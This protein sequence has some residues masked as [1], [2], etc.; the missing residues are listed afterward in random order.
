VITV[1][2]H[3]KIGTSS[4]NH[5]W[6]GHYINIPRHVQSLNQFGYDT[7]LS[8]CKYYDLHLHYTNNIIIIKYIRIISVGIGME[9][10]D[11]KNE[12][13]FPSITQYFFLS[14]TQ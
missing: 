7:N 3:S 11:D 14:P 5:N 4:H 12:W 2:V 6:P 10:Y 1:Q 8:I 13:F 9:K